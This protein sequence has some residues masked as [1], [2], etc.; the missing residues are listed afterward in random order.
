M[1]QIRVLLQKI[2]LRI[3]PDKSHNE[4]MDDIEIEMNSKVIGT[5]EKDN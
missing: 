1:I 5:P 2:N 4:M 3:G